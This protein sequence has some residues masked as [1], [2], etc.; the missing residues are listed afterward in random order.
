MKKVFFYFPEGSTKK[1]SKKVES[2]DSQGVDF[3]EK[4]FECSHCGK[5]FSQH[6]MFK[7]HQRI[8]TEERPYK[9]SQCGLSFRWRR[10]LI[11]HQSGHPGDNPVQ[12]SM[13]DETFISEASLKKHQDAFHS[14]K[15]LQG[16][17]FLKR[18][19]KHILS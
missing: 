13:C 16:S 8:H 9:C 11:A 1:P 17:G 3:Q 5:R 15:K 6:C 4:P 14:G 12:C 7:I 19:V 18:N 2:T 10:N